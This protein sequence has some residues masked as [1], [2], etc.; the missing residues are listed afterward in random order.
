[1]KQPHSFAE[2]FYTPKPAVWVL[3]MRVVLFGFFA[4]RVMSYD[5]A[6]FGL[7]PE[8]VLSV[9]PAMLHYDVELNYF[10][11]VPWV[12]DMAT[13]HWIHWWLP[14]PNVSQL[15]HIQWAVCGICLI[16]VAGGRGPYHLF[17]FMAIA[18]VTYLWG[19][20]WRSGVIDSMFPQL[21]MAWVYSL[22]RMVEPANL[23]RKDSYR[24]LTQHR[25]EFGALYSS[26]LII[27][28]G[29][30][31][32]SGINKWSDLPLP[33]WFNYRFSHVH[34]FYV[35]AVDIAG[36]DPLIPKFL[37]PFFQFPLLDFI[38][39]ALIYISHCLI[40]LM[41]F[42]RHLIPVFMVFYLWFHVLTMGVYTLF[43][44]IIAIWFLFIPIQTAFEPLRIQSAV[45]MRWLSHWCWLA[46]VEWIARQSD[47]ASMI[48]DVNKQQSY[49]LF[50]TRSVL[51]LL[52]VNPL[53]WPLLALASCLYYTPLL[54]ALWIRPE[55]P[56]R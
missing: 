19:F 15:E 22:S 23:L 1:M 7:A 52:W 32:T 20:L 45:S 49:P 44:E 21:A 8:S 14:L 42:R 24:R 28:I 50:S 5:F 40:P 54:C 36:F 39:P 9:Y 3:W 27:W 37:A 30:Y 2:L 12:V 56:K 16:V 18:G 55:K 13:F 34:T 38:F 11:G 41:Y 6:I 10:L 25:S 51:R 4:W 48:I 26:V 17:S 46:P 29:Y 33:D 31:F 47:Q 35:Q 43:A 53:G